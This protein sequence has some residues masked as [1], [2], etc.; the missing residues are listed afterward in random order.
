MKLSIGPSLFEW[1]KQGFKDFYKRMA[2]ETEAD[3]IYLG[4]VVCSKRYN[5]EPGEMV[6]LAEEL[7]SSGKEIVFST[8]GLVMSDAEI[9]NLKEIVAKAGELGLMVEANDMAGISEAEGKPMVAGP[10]ITTY[11]PETLDFLTDVGV[12]RVVFP[13]E[14]SRDAVTGIISRI[15]HQ[16]VEKEL[17]AFGKLPLTFS[18]RCYTARA[19][20]LP[21]SNCQ[22]KCGE[23]PDG[24]EM[25]TQEGVA[26][27]TVNGIQTMSAQT[28]NLVDRVEEIGEMG[29]DILRLSPQSTHMVEAVKIFRER[30]AGTM[31]AAEGVAKLNE[32][33]GAGV[34]CN[35]YYHGKAG[36]DWD[37]PLMVHA[38][39]NA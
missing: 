15:A 31:D 24:M 3:I 21:K 2:F 16:A 20:K 34:F 26:F 1:G 11:N 28:F 6:E 5:L 30:I 12:K 18:A 23:Y 33:M 4:E 19:Y 36:L 37:D 29:I 8:L 13:V 27:L 39:A 17:F 32:L 22:Y 25:K 35:G 7:K 14:L 9:E 38:E 10:H